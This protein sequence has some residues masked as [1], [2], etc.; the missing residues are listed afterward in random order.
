[1]SVTVI[2]PVFNGTDHL[3]D[4]LASVAN[5]TFVDFE[6]IVVDDGST[7]GSGD[8][9]R[10][11][12][13]ADPRTI[14]I[15]QTN[16]GLSA[17][18]NT[19]LRHARSSSEFVLFI[20]HDDVM[21]P[22]ALRLLVEALRTAPAAIA[23]H[24][25][26]AAIDRDGKSVPLVRDEASVRKTVTRPE[27]FWTSRK[28]ARVLDATE[29]SGFDALAYVLFI[30]TPGQVLLRKNALEALG[31]FDPLLKMAQDY[32][33]WLRVSARAPLVCVPE[34]VLDYRQTAN[35]MSADQATTRREDLHARFKAITDREIP[36][37]TR[38]LGR[39]LHRHHEWHRAADR[40]DL[41]R[42]SLRR[43]DRSGAA[44]E[45][46]RASR[47]VLEA[48]IAA[49]PLALSFS[50]RVSRYRRSTGAASR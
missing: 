13:I 1:M 22:D 50:M 29:P 4:N 10:Q 42:E 36:A 41:L 14:L 44:R 33:L 30:Y 12:A 19:G 6:H 38:E 43:G 47:S 34:V 3:G 27:R 5:Q 18:R 49:V 24:G 9:V 23:A 48:L 39:H 32:D 21:R 28:N 20:D 26:V 35:S 11:H 16:K 15:A 31:G 37:Q 7:D 8:L 2:T 25:A 40:V 17:A 46:V 45:L